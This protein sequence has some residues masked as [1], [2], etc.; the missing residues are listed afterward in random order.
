MRHLLPLVLLVCLSAP[1]SGAAQGPDVPN[2]KRQALLTALQ[3]GRQAYEVGDYADALRHYRTAR[4]LHEIPS[5]WFLEA[6]CLEKLDRPTRAIEAYERFL[7]HALV[8]PRRESAVR[9]IA[10]LRTRIRDDSAKLRVKTTPR[11]AQVLVEGVTPRQEIS[12][13]TLIGAGGE[14]VVLTL[15]LSG[16]V[17]Q[18]RKVRLETGRTL[19]LEVTLLPLPG[20]PPV[21][22]G[23]WVLGGLGL[24]SALGGGASLILS[25]VTGGQLDAYDASRR[26]PGS[27]RP[28]DYDAVVARHNTSLVLGWS[29]LGVAV[30]SGAGAI[31]WWRG[32]RSDSVAWGF[33]PSGLHA[34]F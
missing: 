29:L 15:A 1:S 20:P 5:L 11:G 3:R 10:L 34:T 19:E 24:A 6:Q 14:E 23:V 33:S 4:D 12:P 30:M 9:S 2:S 25:G 28:A 18:R 13:V 26:T 7:Q 21:P 16:H 8:D 27:Q 22:T 32:S 31:W 17:S